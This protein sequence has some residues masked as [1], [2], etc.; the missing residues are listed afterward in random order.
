MDLAWQE[1]HDSQMEL[2]RDLI[3][4]GV[5]KLWYSFVIIESCLALLYIVL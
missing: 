2:I 4:L 5:V 3:I 1:T